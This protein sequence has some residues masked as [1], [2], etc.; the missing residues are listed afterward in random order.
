MSNKI[1]IL[2][3]EIGCTTDS[4]C[5]SKLACINGN[6]INPCEADP[7]GLNAECVVLDSLPVRTML[8][9]CL[10]GYEGDASIECTPVKTCPPGKGLIFDENENCVC[11]PGYT[12]DDDGNCVLCRTDLG[13]IIV[14]GKCICDS[15]RGLVFDAISG[16]CTC[17][18]GYRLTAPITEGG[19][20]EESKFTISIF[21]IKIH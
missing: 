3:V 11:P 7:C 4:E 9:I 17:P 2:S 14:G 12:F 16:T 18:P 5:G 1:S 15:S 21:T 19:V 8:C 13:F 6:C 10:E 20:C